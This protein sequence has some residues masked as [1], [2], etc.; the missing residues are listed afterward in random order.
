MC[1]VLCIEISISFLQWSG[2]TKPLPKNVHLLTLE[3]LP[4]NPLTPIS[5]R[6]AI[7][8]LEHFYENGEDEELS[9]PATVDLV[10]V[11]T[12]YV[13]VSYSCH[14]VGSV[15]GP[16]RFILPVCR[17]RW[18]LYTLIIYAHFSSHFSLQLLMA[19]I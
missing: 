4:T 10:S 15:F 3:M 14:N 13:L 19:E 5:L 12:Y 9:Q 6:E 1:F 8:R 18:F 2:L 17:L 11:F 16:V 7:L